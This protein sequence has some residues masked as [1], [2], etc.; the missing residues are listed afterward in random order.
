[1]LRTFLIATLSFVATFA[2][3]AAPFVLVSDVDDTVKI[4][5]V[6]NR[7]RAVRNAISS[8]LVFAGMAELYRQLLGPDSPHERLRFISGSPRVVRDEIHEMLDESDFPRYDLTVR[9]NRD[10]RGSVL[11]FKTDSLKQ[12]YGTARGPFILIGDDTESDPDVYEKFAAS[13]PG[14]VLAIYIR[15]IRGVPLPAGQTPFVT[16]YDIAVQERLAGRLTDEQ[17]TAVGNAVLESKGRTL[18][19]SFQICPK[20]FEGDAP[21]GVKIQKRLQEICADRAR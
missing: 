9:R 21:L 19:P 15:Q 17:V 11:R 20:R 16:A 6:L 4:T 5:S 13:K 2:N 3:A 7:S 18:L 12:L 1:M 14:Q 8:E 10:V